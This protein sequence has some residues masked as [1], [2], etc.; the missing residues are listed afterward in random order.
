MARM[1]KKK[2]M[3]M[4]APQ[5][6]MAQVATALAP[7]PDYRPLPMPDWHVAPLRHKTARAPP[8]A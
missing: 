8:L 6:P 4:A 7:V 3:T 5:T 1:K 2:P